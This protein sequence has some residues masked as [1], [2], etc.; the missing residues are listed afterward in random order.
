[1]SKKVN[2]A[3]AGATGAVGEEMLATLE[4]RD[5]PI[6]ELHLFASSRSA[7]N[8][9]MFKGKQY[10]IEE[11]TASSFDGK[12]ID[13]ALFSAGASRSKEFAPYA[14]K[15]GAVVVDNSSAFRADDEIPL[16]V[17]EV[18]ANRI[19]EHKGII[20]NPNCSTIQMVVALKPIHDVSPIKRVVVSTYQA[21]S[22]AGRAAMMECEEQTR[23][24]LAGQSVTVEKFQHQLAF[25]LIPHIDSFLDSGY[26]KEEMKMVHETHKIMEAPNMR[27]S[28][29]CVR[30]PV[31]RAHSESI[32]IE[33]ERKITPEEAKEI[34]SK[35]KGIVIEDNPSQNLYPMPLFVAGKDEVYLG[36]IR[37]DISS[38]TGLAFW[39]VGD[40]LLKGAAL[41]AVQIAEYLI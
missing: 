18:N 20:A 36:R 13:I 8:T 17:P 38:D 28:A 31:I 22:G 1:M 12:N 35:A 27:I 3:I 24:V 5:F 15:A 39:C 41:N 37:E 14:V 29:T 34:W 16:I 6:G 7:G 32:Y 21:S 23:Q 33:T 2:V 40:Q 30:V 25:N 19:K 26:T 11:L 10:K 9:L 4:K